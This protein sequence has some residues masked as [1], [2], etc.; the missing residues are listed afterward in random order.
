M[1]ITILTLTSA[2][3]TLF[4]A[5]KMDVDIRG[6][7]NSIV[8]INEGK[9]LGV[10]SVEGKKEKD[11]KFDKAG[12]IIEKDT[13]ISKLIGNKKKKS[14]FKALKMD[15]KVDIRFAGPV[16]ESDPIQAKAAELVILDK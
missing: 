8:K 14:D 7:I 3:C 11:T 4:K 13:K 2:G 9:T 10:I 1:L 5:K 15:Q 12:V 6:K 16:M